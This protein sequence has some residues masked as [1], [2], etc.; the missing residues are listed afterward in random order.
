MDHDKLLGYLKLFV[1]AIVIIILIREIGK[2]VDHVANVAR[3][4][5]QQVTLMALRE[6]WSIAFMVKRSAPAAAGVVAKLAD[7][8]CSLAGTLIACKGAA[9]DGS[10]GL[11]IF[12]IAESSGVVG[13]PTDIDLDASSM[14][15]VS[16]SPDRETMLDD[17]RAAWLTAF[18]IKNSA[19]TAAEIAAIIPHS[20]CSSAAIATCAGVVRNDGTLAKFTLTETGGTIASPMDI[21][22]YR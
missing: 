2:R 3:E 1:V 19:P 22:V 21:G 11:A 17:L 8:K 15:V 9:N 10:S 16:R 14:A 5:S 20:K 12:A 6:A 18:K 7:S 13:S 4:A